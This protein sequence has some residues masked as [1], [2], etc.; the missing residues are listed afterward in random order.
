MDRYTW[1]DLIIN[2]NTEEAKNAV[3]KEC[4][5]ANN[6]MGCL[7]LANNDRKDMLFTLDH[8][9]EDCEYPF[10]SEGGCF[11]CMI[12][13]KVEYR[14]LA[15]EWIKDNGVKVGDYVKITR[16]AQNFENGWDNVWTTR[17]N[18]YVGK[19]MVVLRTDTLDEGISLSC[20][21]TFYYFP[22]FVLEKV[23]E[24]QYVPFKSAK[25]FVQA[26]TR[27]KEELVRYTLEDNLVSCGMWIRNKH[28]G[29]LHQVVSLERNNVIINFEVDWESL[30][31][32]YEFLDGSPCG[33][34]LE[35]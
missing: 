1:N 3:G 30:L 6:P 35:R 15:R 25:E 9:K 8:L 12:V 32:H 34:L 23:N 20:S 7:E 26:Y 11:S 22:Y 18:E 17:M 10:F 21:D 19:T 2:P 24:V 28:D 31:D 29:A 14:D 4:Y 16:K 13:R 33:K 27:S 5:Y